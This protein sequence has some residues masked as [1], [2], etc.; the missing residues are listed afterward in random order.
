MYKYNPT[1]NTALFYLIKIVQ[2]AKLC[3]RELLDESIDVLSL[4]ELCFVTVWFATTL[5]PVWKVV[6]R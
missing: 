1:T 4:H 5:S 6:S 3:R 2:D